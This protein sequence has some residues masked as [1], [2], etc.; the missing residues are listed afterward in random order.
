[1]TGGRIWICH[2]FSLGELGRVLKGEKQ[3][4]ESFDPR[5]LLERRAN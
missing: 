3:E 5:P 4:L 1:M 2:I